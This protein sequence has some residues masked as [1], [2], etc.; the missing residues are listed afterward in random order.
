MAVVVELKDK[1][2]S[3]KDIMWVSKVRE[4]VYRPFEEQLLDEY[5]RREIP[6]DEYQDRYEKL[7]KFTTYLITIRLAD[8]SELTEKYHT[9]KDAIKVHEQIIEGMEANV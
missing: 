3:C 2:I 4:D 6:W 9:K 8:G 7:E 1:I 5:I